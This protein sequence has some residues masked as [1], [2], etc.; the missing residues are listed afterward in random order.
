MRHRNTLCIKY[1]CTATQQQQ[2]HQ[3]RSEACLPARHAT[4]QYCKHPASACNTL[5]CQHTHHSHATAWREHLRLTDTLPVQVRVSMA[6]LAREHEHEVVQHRHPAYGEHQQRSILEC[7]YDPAAS[8]QDTHSISISSGSG[9]S[10]PQGGT[11]H[12]TSC[13]SRRPHSGAVSCSPSQPLVCAVILA[14]HN[15]DDD[16]HQRQRQDHAADHI[17]PQYI[18]VIALCVMQQEEGATVT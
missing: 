16:G 17:Q 18:L 14:Q 13:H 9:K 6:P 15:C 3:Q 12:S 11:G 7:P 1:V 8:Q 5:R 2:R 10:R 4:R